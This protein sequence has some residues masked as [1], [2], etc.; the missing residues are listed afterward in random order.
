MGVSTKLT[1]PASMNHND[2]QLGD[3][4]TA[5]DAA[6]LRTPCRTSRKYWHLTSA[7]ILLG[8]YLGMRI[9]SIRIRNVHWKPPDLRCGVH[10]RDHGEG[11]RRAGREPAG[12]RGDRSRP[13]RP[14][15]HP[16]N[17]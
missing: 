16:R 15:G 5:S 7:G 8:A 11:P 4:P 17:L 1:P 2:P 9:L 6:S 3:T 12:L 14:Q 13:G 10:R